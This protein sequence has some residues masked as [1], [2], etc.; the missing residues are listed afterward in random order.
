MAEYLN[1]PTGEGPF[2]AT[3]EQARFILWWF[4]IDERG[5]FVYRTGV[6]QRLKGH[7][8]DPLAAA[9]SLVELCGPSR[10][11]HFDE[12]GSP[13]GTRCRNALVMVSA[14]N[15]EQ[16][17]NTADMFPVLM[18]PQFRSEFG[19][20]AGIELIRAFGGTSKLKAVTSS[21]RALEGARS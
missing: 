15:Q 3:A 14:V 11:S 7:G 2:K 16:T 21:P 4:A 20:D 13:V 19:I 18:T 6:M 17:S 10:F 12:S 1:S 8:K 5:E 9:L